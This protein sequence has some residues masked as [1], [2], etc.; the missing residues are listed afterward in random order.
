M[1]CLVANQIKKSFGSLQALKGVDL[2][3][4]SGEI[5][6]LLGENGAGKTT[7]MN[8]LFGL[9]SPDSG[10]LELDG[11]PYR[12]E[13]PRDAMAAGVGMVHQHF[14]LVPTLTVLENILL[15]ENPFSLHRPEESGNRIAERMIDLSFNLP[16]ERRIEDLSVGERQR[17]E[18]FKALWRGANLLIL[19]EP[20]AV[21]AP[22]EV[23]DLFRLL[24]ELKDR[25]CSI[26]F[27]SHKLD[28]I[29]DLC[30]RVTLLRRGETV[31]EFEVSQVDRDE[32][33]RRLLGRELVSS[34]RDR[35]GNEEDRPPFLLRPNGGARAKLQGNWTCEV[36][37]GQIT[38]IA[39]IE[40]NGQ[41]E[42]AEAVV[43]VS[44]TDRV[45]V[46]VD[47]SFFPDGSVP[48]IRS[49][50]GLISEDRQRTG[51]V[52]EFTIEENLAL[53]D[54]GQRPW[55]KNG[56]LARSSSRQTAADLID[57]FGVHPS[58]PN[59]LAS[60]LSGG[61]QQKVVVAR[62]ISRDHQLLVAFNP[63]RGLD[64]GACETVYEALLGDAK[65]GA[66]ILLISTEL[67]HALRLADR[68][69]V[70][71][72]GRL[73]EIH[74]EDWTAERLGFAMLGEHEG[75]EG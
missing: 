10:S 71:F 66:A 8:I 29:Q 41:R 18:I 43:G 12:P 48:R 2:K 36:R 67:E 35:Q 34:E 15:G 38:A 5:H 4:E 73:T 33:T 17:V 49:G 72:G 53:K 58:E 52:P 74:R 61:N 51:L 55:S 39:G 40:G 47:G 59:R 6:A 45:S 19:D 56:W 3:V 22:Q 50:I 60:E 31:G 11:K 32:L 27:I 25:E 23:E 75:R 14:M 46:E 21:L 37:P 68:L 20:T 63:T 62:E 13:S 16:L 42:L 24:R 7:L 26:L 64:V 1:T 28:E 57:R 70:L 54:I 69:Y 30:D 65:E 9:L 44:E